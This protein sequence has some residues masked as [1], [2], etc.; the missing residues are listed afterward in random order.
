MIKNLL[1]DLGGVI[2]DIRRERCVAAFEALGLRDADSYFGLYAQSG[3]FMALES[4][5][6]GPAEFRDAVRASLTKPATDSQI[7]D[8]LNR[9][10]I[11]IPVERLRMLERL[12]GEGYGMYLLSNTNPIMWDGKIAAEFRK[13]GHDMSHYFAGEVTSFAARCAKPDAEIFRLAARQLG[14]E[15]SETM[16]FDDSEQNLRAA[17]REGYATC[18]VPEAEDITDIITRLQ[19][20]HEI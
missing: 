6:V 10:L 1:F 7:D 20:E 13:D 17:A 15:P 9:F 5:K 12:R 18:L 3:V 19:R 11:G 2:M 14:I 16:F 8:A 4:G